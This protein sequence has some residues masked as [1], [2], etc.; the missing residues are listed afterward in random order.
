VKQYLTVTLVILV[1]ITSFSLSQQLQK[2]PNASLPKK[3][4]VGEDITYVVKYL[5]FEIGEIRLKVQKE[6]F[7]G[8]DTLYSAIAYIDS[9][10]GIPFVDLHQIYETKFDQRQISHF[11]KGTIISN[12]TTYTQYDFERENKKIHIVK[13]RERAN[14]PW[15][16]ST[17]NYDRDYQ[18]GLSLFYFARMRT[19]HKNTLKVPVFINEKYEKTYIN[20]YDEIDDKDIDAVDYDIACV[21]L[22]GETEFRG[23]LG[24]T[25]YFEGWFSADERAVPIIAK[26]QVIIGSITLELKNWNIKGWMPPKYID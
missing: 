6:E 17:A 22:D 21:R 9:Y 1:F 24:L 3:V 5:M 8:K 23:I 14:K 2:Y 4:Q 11:F 10:I 16:D 26:M 7:S 19:G 25:G 15:T 18:D 20:F 12:D 13:G